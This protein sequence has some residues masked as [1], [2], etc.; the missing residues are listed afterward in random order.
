MYDENELVTVKWNNNNRDWY[1]SLGYQ[2]TKRFEEFVVPVKHLHKG[3]IAI[4][5]VVCDYC[6]RP[7]RSEYYELLNR[8]SIVPKDACSRCTGKKTSDVSKHR[9]AS[10]AFSL[11]RKSCDKYGYTLITKENEYTGKRMKIKYIC[12]KHGIQEVN[13]DNIIHG[14]K[15]FK[16]SYET[17]FDTMMIK[18]DEVESKIISAGN[19]WLNKQ[20]YINSTTRNLRIQCKCGNVYTT[21][22]QIFTNNDQTVCSRCSKKESHGER[23][24]REFLSENKIDFEQEKRFQDC[25]DKKALPF[26]FYLPSKNIC[27]EFDGIYHYQPI[28]GDEHF[29]ITQMHDKIKNKYCDDNG[30]KLI[31]IPY[32]AKNKIREILKS[33]IEI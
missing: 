3:S 14:R 24:I 22:Y 12:P 7:Y 6:G 5:N 16:C 21:S 13:I 32:T 11:L 30:I 29:L 17:R 9:R 2:F 10:E 15:C 19:V 31:R 18:A 26:D 23:R 28:R 4:V 33:E 8:R 1:E 27:I 25:R 20:E